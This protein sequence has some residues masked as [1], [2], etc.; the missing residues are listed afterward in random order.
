L[1][2]KTETAR[3]T[4]SAVYRKRPEGLIATVSGP[5]SALQLAAG[6]HAT[7][8]GDP[9]S[10]MANT[11]TGPGEKESVRYRKRPEGL[12]ATPWVPC[13]VV[14]LDAGLQAIGE[15][16]PSALIANGD[17]DPIARGPP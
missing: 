8:D 16:E 6:V 2:G 11:S 10:L 13:P 17:I 7:G 12:T 15:S 3:D 5:P 9:S 1:I 4:A 14:Q